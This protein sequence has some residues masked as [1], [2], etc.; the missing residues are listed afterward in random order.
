MGEQTIFKRYEIKYMLTK[1][2]QKI[3]KEAMV[4]H[5]I[6]D[7]HGKST[8]C[9][10]YFDTPDFLLARRSM[11]HPVYK[12][13]LRLRSYGVANSDSQVFVE[14]KKKYDGIVYKRRVAMS[15]TQSKKYLY[16]NHQLEDTKLKEELLKERE[17]LGFG[18]RQIYKEIDYCLKQYEGIKPQ[19]LLTYDREAYYA[20]D[21]HEFRMTFDENILWRDYDV[22]LDK[23]IYGE[24]VIPEDNV[25]MEVKV[26]GAMPMWLVKTLNE[27][28]IRSTNFSK[29]SSAY[30]IISERENKEN[31]T[32][33]GGLKSYAI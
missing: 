5:M 8:I 9:S 22:V 17:N 2:Q 24:R 19:V 31:N 20:K 6:P 4:E 15:E 28:E 32:V 10:L 29:Y 14:L 30:K 27:N 7:V 16:R 18:D 3:I 11:D 33:N 21:D 13:K 23:G 12:E 1:S 26:G 25:L